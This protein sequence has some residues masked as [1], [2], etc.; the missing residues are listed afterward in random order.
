MDNRDEERQ[1]QSNLNK[2]FEHDTEKN[3]PKKIT[4]QEEGEKNETSWG[5]RT[6]EALA[7]KRIMSAVRHFLPKMTA[8]Q[9]SIHHRL[10]SDQREALL[11][12]IPF[13]LFSLNGV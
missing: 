10:I 13:N 4:S 5:N 3:E 1:N 11:C 6:F 12:R 2:R 9:Y 8:D 7:Y